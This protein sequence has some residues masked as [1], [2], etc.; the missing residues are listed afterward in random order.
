MY[1]CKS[2]VLVCLCVSLNQQG[3][4]RC[5]PFNLAGLGEEQVI[6]QTLFS[7]QTHHAHTGTHTQT[8]EHLHLPE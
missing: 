8:G 7:Q 5:S 3:T 4:Y 2:F 6:S 1:V